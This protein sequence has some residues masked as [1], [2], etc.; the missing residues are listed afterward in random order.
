M[1][2]KESFAQLETEATGKKIKAGNSS[3]FV[4]LSA[5]SLVP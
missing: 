3:Y 4:R 5:E 1:E 2:K